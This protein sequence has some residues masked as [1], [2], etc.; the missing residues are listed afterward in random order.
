MSKIHN[1]N[2]FID[3]KDLINCNNYNIHIFN[4]RSIVFIN[5]ELNI[6]SIININ[7]ILINP[8][9][10]KTN[11][12]QLNKV[13]KF[14]ININYSNYDLMFDFK[15]KNLKVRITI[16]IFKFYYIHSE[17]SIICS[18]SSTFNKRASHCKVLILKINDK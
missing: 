9:F 1:E 10:L 7:D 13:I 17:S 6:R 5:K 4:N 2:S 8:E 3:D 15:Y 16:N 11:I 14:L 18:I 12:K